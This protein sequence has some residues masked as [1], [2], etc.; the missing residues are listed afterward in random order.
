[1][2]FTVGSGGNTRSQGQLLYTPFLT[3]GKAASLKRVEFAIEQISRAGRTEGILTAQNWKYFGED[4]A[5]AQQASDSIGFGTAAQQAN[6]RFIQD[7]VQRRLRMLERHEDKVSVVTAVNL[8]KL[9]SPF[10]SETKKN[11][12]R[13]FQ[14]AH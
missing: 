10:F 13:C 12:M 5:V 1:V 8:G 7:K 9:P 11:I 3:V 14:A 2:A 4:I 6:P